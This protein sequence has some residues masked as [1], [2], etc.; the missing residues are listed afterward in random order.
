MECGSGA[1]PA[2]SGGRPRRLSGCAEG[3]GAARAASGWALGRLR[4]LLAA[5]RRA[6][7]LTL[8]F[9]YEGGVEVVEAVQA[10]VQRQKEGYEHLIGE[11]QRRLGDVERVP[12]EG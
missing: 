2:A 8:T 9:V 12:G 6:G 3:C 11:H 7:P 10:H 1:A 4:A 5:A